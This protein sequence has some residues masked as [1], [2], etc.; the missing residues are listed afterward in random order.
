M[1]LARWLADAL[2]DRIPNNQI[3]P[4]QKRNGMPFVV[5]CLDERKD[6]YIIV[7]VTAAM[8]FGD[9]KAK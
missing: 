2:R 3:T 8:E 6:V 4:Q 1:R 5:A 9:L 7:G